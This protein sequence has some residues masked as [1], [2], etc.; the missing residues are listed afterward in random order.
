MNHDLSHDLPSLLPPHY[1][2]I[3]DYQ[4]ICSAENTEFEVLQAAILQTLANFFIQTADEA[5]IALWEKAF[6]IAANPGTETLDYRRQRVLTRIS[7]QPPFTLTFLYR[8][9]DQIIGPGKWDCTVDY[10]AYTLAVKSG[11][12]NQLYFSQ[13]AAL[14]SIIKPAHMAFVNVPLFTTGILITETIKVQAYAHN[15]R[16]GSWA[17][18]AAPFRS[19]TAEKSAKENTA[20]S[21]RPPL[22]TAL[23]EKAGALVS[24]AAANEDIILAELTK[25]IVPATLRSESSSYTLAGKELRISAQLP[26]GEASYNVTQYR[27]LDAEQA[28]LFSADCFFPVKAQTEVEVRCAML[29][30]AALA[31]TQ[32]GDLVSVTPALTEPQTLQVEFLEALA[33]HLAG[34][35]SA[36]QLNGSYT[37]EARRSVSGSTVTVEYDLAPTEEL[38]T[39]Q[40]ITLL[41]ADGNVLT[42]A[43]VNIPVTAQMTIQ[44]TL[45]LK[46]GTLNYGG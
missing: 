27:L 34:Q 19:I 20:P 14:I 12:E 22:F 21:A 2:D 10:P 32:D 3:Q 24:T 4:Q 39:I 28:A 6:H 5:T 1:R 26:Q 9:L 31:Q 15:Y 37:A 16:L 11:A 35:I 45:N 25:S 23:A 38:G 40:S 13:L 44:H 30:G 18:G 33:A 46:E 36:V 42:Q 17:L 43:Q 8:K 29:E 41:D 7:M